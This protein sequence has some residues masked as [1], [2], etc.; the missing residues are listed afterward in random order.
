MPM[1]RKSSFLRRSS[2]V[3]TLKWLVWQTHTVMSSVFF[4]MNW[5]DTSDVEFGFKNALSAF[6]RKW[7]W[8]LQQFYFFCQLST[9]N[10]I[11]EIFTKF[12]TNFLPISHLS[13]KRPVTSTNFEIFSIFKI[14]KRSRKRQLRVLKLCTNYAH[15]NSVV[16]AACV[17]NFFNNLFTVPKIV[18]FIEFIILRTFDNK[19]L[20][21]SALQ[22]FQTY[23]VVTL[24]IRYNKDLKVGKFNCSQAFK[25]VLIPLSK[26]S[27]RPFQQVDRVIPLLEQRQQCLGQ[28]DTNLAPTPPTRRS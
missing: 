12:R 1:L 4:R 23:F 14:F 15:G 28:V 24:K 5:C 20:V 16:K 22:S 25:K 13:S 7:K 3:K 9:V 8:S 11:N 19:V 27:A 6:L 10:D 18:W 21:K 17:H 2:K 26:D